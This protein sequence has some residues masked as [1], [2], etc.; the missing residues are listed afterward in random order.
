MWERQRR[1]AAARGIL[2][3][4]I[5]LVVGSC[6]VDALLEEFGEGDGMVLYEVRHLGVEGG[7]DFLVGGDEGRLMAVAS[8]EVLRGNDT[9]DFP[10]LG[11]DEEDFGVVVGEVGAL[12]RL[13]DESPE[14]ES[15]VGGFVVEN[16]VEGGDV[17]RLFDEEESS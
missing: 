14:F 1:N 3:R 2:L 13:G 6:C 12:H 15:L 17:A 9:D 4:G 7:E 8:R 11:L 10:R 16:E 5:G